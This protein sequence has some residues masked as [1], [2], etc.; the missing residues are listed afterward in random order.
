MQR[1]WL[2]TS[3]PSDGGNQPAHSPAT[4]H[5]PLLCRA[6]VF[7][8]TQ[9][10]LDILEKHVVSQVGRQPSSILPSSAAPLI[11]PWPQA[12][13]GRLF[14]G[15]LFHH[16]GARPSCNLAQG[17]SYHRMDG[18]TGVAQRA[19]LMDDFNNNPNGGWQAALLPGCL[20]GLAELAPCKHCSEPGPPAAHANQL[21]SSSFCS[22]GAAPGDATLPSIPPP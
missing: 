12:L 3:C 19:R 7:T 16:W 14:G 11:G 15:P 5:P 20:A 4:R 21:P 1:R 10:M 9:Q 22:P 18:S 2:P 8:Q 17:Y 6:L 13:L